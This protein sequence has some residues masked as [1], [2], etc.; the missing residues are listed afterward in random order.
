M[1]ERTIIVLSDKFEDC[2]NQLEG[3]DSKIECEKTS[4][5][6]SGHVNEYGCCDFIQDGAK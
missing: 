2:M 6:D 1:P 4:N 5:K 3:G